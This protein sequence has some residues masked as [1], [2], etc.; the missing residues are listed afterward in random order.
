MVQFAVAPNADFARAAR[1]HDER[2]PGMRRCVVED[3]LV[4]TVL[5]RQIHHPLSRNLGLLRQSGLSDGRCS[6]QADSGERE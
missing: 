5:E 1:Q 3:A 4:L 6:E 2:R